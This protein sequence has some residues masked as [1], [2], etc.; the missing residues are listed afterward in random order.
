MRD[1][2]KSCHYASRCAP[3]LPWR[4]WSVVPLPPHFFA[5]PSSSR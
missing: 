1:Q 3:W 2:I 4:R 5:A